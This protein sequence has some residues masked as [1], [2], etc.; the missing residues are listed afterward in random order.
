MY[1]Y[2]PSIDT[3]LEAMDNGKE[4]PIP[5]VTEEL[6]L[7]IRSLERRIDDLEKIKDENR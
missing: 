4:A 1:V 6:L 2:K 7:W 5:L 3:A